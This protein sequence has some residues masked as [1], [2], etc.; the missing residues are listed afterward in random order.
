MGNDDWQEVTYKKRRSVF[1]R[2]GNTI[3]VYVSNFPSHLYVRELSNI[4][5]KKGTIGDVYIAKHKNKYGQMFGFCRFS[6]IESL[7]NLIDSLNKVWIGKLCLHANVARFD[8]SKGFKPSQ[9]QPK[10]SVPVFKEV[11]P[12][13]SSAAFKGVHSSQSFVNAVKGA[14]NG[15]KP[16]SERLH[17]DD[18]SNVIVS[19]EDNNELKLAVLG[20]HK[21]FRVIANSNIICRNEGFVGVDVKYLGGLWVM[22]IFNDMKA[23]DSFLHHEGE[24]LFIDDNDTSNRYSIR[25][26]IKS[27]HTSLIFA[28]TLVTLNGVTCAYRVRELCCWTPNF[29]SDIE[30]NKSEG[31]SSQAESVNDDEESVGEFFDNDG[32]EAYPNN[33][34]EHTKVNDSAHQP[35]SDPFNLEPLIAKTGLYHNNE[36]LTPKFPPGFT[37]SVGD[38]SK[39]DLS[40]VSK[41]VSGKRQKE[42]SVHQE[43][44][45]S[46]DDVKRK[47][48]GVS[49][50]QQVEDTIKVGTALG[51]NMDGC[52]DM[53]AKMI[54]DMGDNFE[55]KLLRADLW[56]LRQVWGNSQ[57]DFASAS[58]RGKS[59]G[60]LCI[61]NKL[62]FNKERV[63]S[64]DSYVAIQG[65]WLQN[66]LKIM[67]I[68][69]YAPQD[70]ASK[71]ILWSNLSQLISNWDGIALIMGDFNEVREVGDRFGSVFNEKQSAMFNSFIT[72]LNLFYIPLGGFRFTWAN[73]WASKMSK[74]DRFLA[75][76][77]FHDAFPNITGSI[78]EKGIPDHRPIFLK[79]LV[80]DYGPTP[81]RFFHS[82]ID[83]EGFSELVTN[84]WK[85]F[86]CGESNGMTSFKKKL[87]HLKSAIRAWSTSKS[88][89]DN[90]IKKDHQN[91]LSLIDAKVD[92][93]V[94]TSD[95][96]NC[97]IAS[98][99]LLSDIDRKE[100]SDI[101]Q[102][103]KVKWALEGDENTSFFHSML[104]KKRRQ[105]AI[106]GILHNGTWIENPGEVKSEFLN[107]F[108]NR[109]SCSNSIR[110]SVGDVTLNQI[111]VDQCK[112]LECDVSDEEIKKAV[113]DCGGDR[114]P[115]PDGFTFKFFKTFWEVIQSDVVRFVREFF[116]SACFPKGCNS[117]FIALIPKVG[118]AKFVSDFRP[119]SLIGCQYKIIG[120]ILA[121]R[122][123]SVIG[124]CVSS[125]QS[126]FIKGRNILDGPLILNEC[127]AWYRK[128][129][130]AL[131]VFKVDFEKAFD[132]LSWDYL[133][134]I[135][136]K[137]GFGTKWRM[138]ISG[139]L[140][141]SRASILVNGSPTSE[142]ELSKGLRQGDPMSPFLFILAMEGLHAMVSKAVTTGLFKGASIG[143]G[144][145]S[146]SHLL[147]ADDAIFVGEWSHTNAYNL[148][149]LLRCFYM[150][151]GLKIN[152]H[153]SK[154][155]GI[156]VD[157][158]DVHNMAHVL[159]CGVANLPMMYL[160]VPVGCN[161]GRC[162]YW[163]HIVNKFESKL[164]QWNANLLSVGGRLSLIKAVLGNLP[165]YYMSL[166]RM[167]RYV[168]KRLE[169][170]RNRFF[171]GGEL[172][173]KKI[174]W[175]WRFRTCPDSLWVNVIKNIHGADGVIGFSRPGYS[176]YSPWTSI[177]HS[178][179]KLQA[180]GIDLL[181]LCSRSVGN[182]LSIRFWNETWCGVCPF[183]DLFPRIYALEENKS[184]TVT[185]R[186][187]IDDWSSV[188]RRLPRG[189]AES[190]Q[191]HDLMEVVR[192]VTLS[193]SNDKWKWDL[194][195]SGFSVSS[196]RSYIDDH[197]L[198][199]SSMST[200]W[201]RF[202]PIKVNV[203]V[204]R[205]CLD[206]LPTLMNLDKKV[207]LDFPVISNIAEWFS[208][209]DSA[210]L[211]KYA[212][213]SLERI[214]S[215]MLWSI[216]NF[217]NAW[218]FS[219][220]KPKKANI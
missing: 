140:K 31:N 159:G 117:S 103:S 120:K 101:A 200:R 22:F 100:A 43:S 151:S 199:G 19:Q 72:N 25:L 92:H 137:L 130:K 184:C 17:G 106:K 82:W 59:G 38:D 113:W 52:Q 6:G 173:N 33:A 93:G 7:E 178:I 167:P 168:Q 169:S 39:C 138:W 8:K 28:S 95:D 64:V 148:I 90:Q 201:S 53:L 125:V 27:S 123:S 67:F 78:L 40:G 209:L 191:F 41:P 48:V 194:D 188:L 26:C 88:L 187:I 86:D 215:T 121:N 115:G 143:Q 15:E 133:D 158:D 16:E 12:N 141:H 181:A 10:K 166:Y 58:A 44:T 91:R 170:M 176:S 134:A 155:S 114:A 190:S 207:V 197:N 160:G 71:I 54:A 23:K 189:E 164:S 147:Y 216:W 84:T 50:I 56:I 62:L 142:F 126:A 75:T 165:T 57:F 1:N 46:D 162:E 198:L 182:G 102:K 83:C 193:S 24:V 37:Q 196:T 116:Q 157:N 79:E 152:V 47:Y 109:L 66:G 217:R 174:T 118:D 212:R 183:K 124:T 65:T 177:V 208:W 60:I 211:S 80:L 185:Q 32:N 14:S 150:M 136:E 149:C 171:L 87:Q 156:N 122:L 76:E 11:K 128:K 35:S 89:T 192:Q 119:I 135:M 34:D 97:R 144:N 104:K 132:S 51:F 98:M 5:G 77:G 85:N 210:H 203:L 146:I 206:K 69:V 81:F 161:M 4:C 74:L 163:N 204:W 45:H 30:E 21:D 213:S 55:T 154:L 186:L 110:P 13:V 42:D 2:L 145:I 9:S 73:K 131:M 179:S 94:A 107:H 111:T 139:C 195:T 153:K 129:K 175:V 49:M 214:A 96:L 127:I 20:C 112:S 220:S 99:K 108:R 70:L 202:I 68:A 180:K 61:W 218:I 18:C 36:S 219:N 3:N 205:L 172:N 29:A 63:I 105:C